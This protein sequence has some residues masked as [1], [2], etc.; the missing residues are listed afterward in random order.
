MLLNRDEAAKR[1]GRSRYTVR[2]WENAGE[3]RVTKRDERGRALYSA[4]DLLD[5]A[6][7]MRS[8]YAQ[9]PFVP[10]SGRGRLHP[11]TPEI[12]RRV[13]AGERTTDIARACGCSVSTVSRIRRKIR[14]LKSAET[15]EQ[16]S[17]G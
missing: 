15:P 10:G 16:D 8:N 12:E 9:R 11:A 14:A 1:L 5:C 7:R 2:D 17:R 13:E 3:L 6:R 4:K